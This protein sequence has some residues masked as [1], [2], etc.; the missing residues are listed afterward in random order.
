MLKESRFDAIEMNV[1]DVGSL[2]GECFM[3]KPDLYTQLL[4]RL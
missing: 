2:L 4:I 3:S 1:V